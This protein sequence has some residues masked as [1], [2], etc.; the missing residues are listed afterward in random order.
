[1]LGR[2]RADGTPKLPTGE[3]AAAVDVPASE[4]VAHT[5]AARFERRE[6]ELRDLVAA[7]VARRRPRVR[8]AECQV[9]ARCSPLGHIR[10]KEAELL[11]E[12]PCIGDELNLKHPTSEQRRGRIPA[13]PTFPIVHRDGDRQTARLQ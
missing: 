5:P 11:L 8:H 10:Q 13:S 3:R 6:D 7:H 12:L 2:E 4:E 1:M 9:D